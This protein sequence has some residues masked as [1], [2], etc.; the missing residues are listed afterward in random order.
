M[1]D[2]IKKHIDFYKSINYN[3]YDFEIYKVKNKSNIQY[4][5]NK[6][7]YYSSPFGSYTILNDNVDKVVLLLDLNQYLIEAYYLY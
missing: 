6:D 7:I 2:K 4:S 3:N 5:N 1:N